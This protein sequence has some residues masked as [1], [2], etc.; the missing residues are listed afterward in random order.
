MDL[1]LS[2]FL[3]EDGYKTQSVP[4]ERFVEL[5]RAAGCA[6]V[7]L[8]TTQIN[9]QMP[10]DQ[11]A[12]RRAAVD[13]CGLRVTCMTPRG[14]P[15]DGSQRDEFFARYLNLAGQM[16]CRL[17]K[18]GGRPQWLRDAAERAGQRGIA[19][20]VNTHLNGPTETVAGTIELLE[21]VGHPNYGL[22]YDCLHLAIA[23]EDYVAAIDR[24]LP[25]VRNILV[26]CVR[27][28]EPGQPPAVS[29]G[30]R[31]FAKARIDEVCLQDWPAVLGRFK[32]L[33]YDGLVTVIENGWPAEQREA[34]A[35]DWAD[36]LRRLWDSL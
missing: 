32:Q 29:H 36:H 34:V 11:I 31:D 33:G 18:I 1:S 12:R 8:R 22:L 35:R 26:Q 27:A 28:A 3:F 25:H 2:G 4:F 7:E 30:G 24:L 16:G 10:P 15:A 17:L 19:L 20:A 5:A 9:L 21:E 14:M 6:G 23:G 13:D